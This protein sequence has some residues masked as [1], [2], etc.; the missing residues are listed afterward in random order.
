MSAKY[1]IGSLVEFTRDKYSEEEGEYMPYS[2]KYYAGKAGYVISISDEPIGDEYMYKIQVGL[3]QIDNVPESHLKNPNSEVQAVI[4]QKLRKAQEKK[5][6][7]DTEGRIGGSKKEKAAYRAIKQIG[8]ETLAEMEADGDEATIIEIIKKDKVYPK[9]DVGAER[10]KGVSAGAAY[11]KVKLRE[12]YGSEPPNNKDKRKV[13]VG[14]AGYLSS[15]MENIFTVEQFQNFALNKTVKTGLSVIIGILSP[16]LKEKINE[17]NIVR[18]K[19]Y[20]EIISNMAQARILLE[21]I[22][23]RMTGEDGNIKFE[24][25]PEKERENVAA[26]RKKIIDDLNE[27]NI[28]KRQYESDYSEIEIEFLKA[29]AG[30]NRISEYDVQWVVRGLFEK[31]FGTRFVNFLGKNLSEKIGEAKSYDAISVEE[32]IEMIDKETKYDLD[33]LKQAKEDLELVD[34]L[35]TKEQHD[36]FFKDRRGTTGFHASYFG[37]P[38]RKK[39]L[40]YKDVVGQE[41]IK[42]YKEQYKRMVRDRVQSLE[43]KIEAAKEKYKVRESNWDWHFGKG[44]TPGGEEQKK[45]SELKV[46]TYP[47]LSHIKRTGGVKILEEDITPDSIRQKFGFKE[48]E[49]GKSLKDKEAKEHVRH[50]LGA[51]ADLADILNFD[52]IHLNKI[53][54]LSIRFASAG[55]GKAS[56]HYES[57]RKAINVTKTRGGGAIAHEYMHYLD[58]ILPKIGRESEYSFREWA[59]VVKMDRYGN[60]PFSV[61]ENSVFKAIEYIFN[62]IYKRQFHPDPFYAMGFAPEEQKQ[63]TEEFAERAKKPNEVKKLVYASDKRFSLPKNFYKPDTGHYTPSDIEDYFTLFKDR[64]SQYRFIENLKKRDFEVLGA[65]VKMFGFKEYEFTFGTKQSLYYANSLK[66]GSDYWSREWELFARA[67]ETYIF[68]KLHKAGRENNY[69]VSGSYFDRPEGVYPQGDERVDLF[70]LYDYLMKMIKAEYGIGDFKPWTKERVDEFIDLKGDEEETV[71]GGVIVNEKTKKKVAVIE[72]DEDAEK[73]DTE[74]KKFVE[75]A[76]LERKMNVIM[77]LSELYSML[78]TKKMEQGGVISE[79][80]DFIN[81]LSDYLLTLKH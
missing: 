17:Q 23:K 41:Q 40:Y 64:Y 24:N 27:L 69:L 7:K 66:M 56:A 65:I 2:E 49:F 44:K 45:S 15:E 35:V 31:V 73:Q 26:V 46:N 36:E 18:K 37:L 29:I 71:E 63:K 52:I 60:S 28:E 30:K 68:D 12:S 14:Y 48:V 53:G 13:Y 70:M 59:S 42:V 3:T 22:E 19:K 33:S 55:S 25:I 51:M 61:K 21:N 39:W 72:P 77:K 75:A 58:N 1:R 78:K 62:Y 74:A 76:I 67:F 4:E 50:F 32:S 9:V 6:F 57:L 10:D 16:E 38:D 79:N 11:L 20:N 80:Q 47:P 8:L 5:E 43:K 54:G 81:K 34:K